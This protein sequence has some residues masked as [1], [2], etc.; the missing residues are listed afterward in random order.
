MIHMP[1]LPDTPENKNSSDAKYVM[2]SFCDPKG[3]KCADEKLDYL[4]SEDNDVCVCDTPCSI[5]RLAY[6]YQNHVLML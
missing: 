4:V 5:I 1:S 6:L 2:P 3:Y